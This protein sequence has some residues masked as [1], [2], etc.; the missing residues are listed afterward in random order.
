MGVLHPMVRTTIFSLVLTVF[1]TQ[2]QAANEQEAQVFMSGGELNYIGG[3]SAAANQKAYALL[4][5]EKPAPTVLLMRS[6]GGPTDEGMALG[7]W[8]RQHQLT[9]KV[10]DVCFSSCANYVFTAAPNKIVSNFAVVGYH[11][12]LSS[13]DFKFDLD[14]EQEKM[15]ASLQEDQ[16]APTRAAMIEQAKQQIQGYMAAELAKES[17]FFADIG[18]QQKITVLGQAPAY[19]QRYGSDE[20]QFLGWYYSLDGLRKLGVDHVEVINGPW[21]PRFTS[22]GAGAAQVFEVGVD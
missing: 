6:P 22:A 5:A 12:G 13:T 1:A 10:L 20:Q 17:K 18:V 19:K 16:R 4:E 14:P 9:V 7:R 2:A 11:G 8:V 21:R 3:I 15:L